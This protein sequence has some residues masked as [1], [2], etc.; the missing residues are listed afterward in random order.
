MVRDIEDAILGTH[1]SVQITLPCRD[2]CDMLYKRGSWRH[3]FTVAAFSRILCKRSLSFFVS[4]LLRQAQ[5]PLK[6]AVYSAF[7]FS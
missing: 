7:S 6:A 4:D 2:A 3:N 5:K 1:E